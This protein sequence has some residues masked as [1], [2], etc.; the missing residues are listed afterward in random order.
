MIDGV[1]TF[2]YSE[3]DILDDISKPKDPL[4]TVT[5]EDIFKEYT[6]KRKYIEPLSLQMI[7]DD[8]EE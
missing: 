6:V 7:E 3:I 2:L 5:V 4:K 8:R 1:P